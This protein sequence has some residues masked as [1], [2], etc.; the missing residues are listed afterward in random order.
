MAPVRESKYKLVS[1]TQVREESF[2]LL[3]YTMKGPRLHFLHSGRLL[4]STFFQGRLTLEQ[5]V[6]E[7]GRPVAETGSCLAALKGALN[8]LKEKG[9]ILEC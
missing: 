1:G 3:F 4:D 6:A 7:H 9:V 8:R 2:G 5:W